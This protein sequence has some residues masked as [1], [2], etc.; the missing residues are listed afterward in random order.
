[1]Q[2]HKKCVTT[3][4]QPKKDQSSLCDSLVFE[5]GAFSGFVSM[6][7]EEGLHLGRVTVGGDNEVTHLMKTGG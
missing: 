7:L 2:S 3:F 1:M 4:T 5:M 6:A